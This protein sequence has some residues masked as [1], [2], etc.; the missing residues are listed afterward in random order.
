MQSVWVFHGINVRFTSGVFESKLLAEVWIA[1]HKL[2][3]TLTEYPLNVGAYDWAVSMDYFTPKKDEHR[4]SE[5]IGKFS[6]ASQ[7]HYHYTD[8]QKE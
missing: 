8:G 7:S 6:S 2:T 3:G 4:T 1:D 5:Y